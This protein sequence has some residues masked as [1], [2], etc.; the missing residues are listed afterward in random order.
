MP[1]CHS[2]STYDP[3]GRATK[4]T[5]ALGNATTTGYSPTS[6]LSITTVVTN[7]LG[8]ATIAK[9]TVAWGRD[10]EDVDIR[11]GNTDY[12]SLGPVLGRSGARTINPNPC[13][14]SQRWPTRHGEARLGRVGRERL[15]G[16]CLRPRI[17]AVANHA[18]TRR[19]QPRSWSCD[20]RPDRDRLGN[21]HVS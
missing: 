10:D 8:N 19:H 6:G 3:Y 15:F 7:A 18:W 17:A 20:R 12:D 5:D 16:S 1:C 4:N 21:A 2:T 13:S 11:S 9:A 14:R